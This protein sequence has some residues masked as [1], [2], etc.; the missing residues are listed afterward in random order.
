VTATER[1]GFGRT[2][3]GGWQHREGWSWKAPFG[4]PAHPDEPAV[5]VSYSEAAA[6]CH[7]ANKRLPTEAEWREAAYTERRETPPVGFVHGRTYP[8]PTGPTPRGANC[9]EECGP[10]RAVATAVTSRGRGHA[11][12][13]STARGVNGLY[14]MGGNVWEWAD[15]GTPAARPTL[16]GSWWYGAD[17]MRAS[18][19]QA[20]PEGMSAVYI[21]FRCA[22]SLPADSHP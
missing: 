9:L 5:H 10:A 21:G 6:Y 2:F 4:A 19:Q 16:G 14:D 11:F 20:K 15:G 1:E 18:H 22:R 3:E 12:V 13:A 8:Y 7:W 17:S